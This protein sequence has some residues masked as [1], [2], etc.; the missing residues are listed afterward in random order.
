MNIITKSGPENPGGAVELNYGSYNTFSPQAVYGGSNKDGDLHYFVSSNYNRTDRGLDT[1]QPSSISNQTQGGT[2]AIHDESNGN[3]EFVKIDWLPN[4]E[5]KFSFMLFQNYNFYQIPNF[6]A[7]FG[8]PGNFAA[9]SGYF[10]TDYNDQVGNVPPTGSPLFTWAPADTND[11][12]SNQDIYGQAVW[13]HTFS[14]RSFLQVTPYWKYSKVKVTNDPANDLALL[15][16]TNP[17]FGVANYTAGALTS[18]ALDQHI[19]NLG[20]RTDYSQRPDDRNLFKTGFQVQATQSNDS[21]SVATDPTGVVAPIVGGDTNR[22]YSE[23]LYAQDD[24]TL[25]KQ[26]SINAGLRFT[27]VQFHFS[28]INTSYDQWQPRVGLNYL[29]TE[30]TKLHA[31]YGRLFMP[32][33]LENLR[34]AFDAAPGGTTANFYDIK[35]EKD[36]YFE[37]GVDQQIAQSHVTK[38][39]VYYKKATDMLDDTQLLNTSIASPYNYTEG[40]AYGI[41][42]SIFGKL[43]PEISDFFNYSYEIAKGKGID[44]GSFAVNPNSIP[45]DTYLYLDHVQVH[46]ANAG[47]TYTKERYF[48][49]VEG[50][51]GSGLRTGPNNTLSLP[52]HFTFDLTAGYDF[53]G[54]NWLTNWKVQGDILN[55]F[56][57]VYPITIANGF[58]GSH[59]AAGREFFIRLTKEL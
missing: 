40:Y 56:D 46:T 37:F 58:N 39:N 43:T 27:G 6:P 49:T 10:G 33:P 13:K 15:N 20:V 30:T 3:N 47:L 45:Q 41:E 53:K 42:Y 31:F 4:N 48:G 8:T 36:N 14:E 26:W 51:F 2:D 28:D 44:G 25:N 18:F 16:P 7:S 9:N 19:N 59:Y 24:F 5:D 38:V 21:F 29:A 52:S 35:P 23:A 17:L 57:N 22:G 34:E 12:Q 1:P 54:E 55:L 50:L 11:T 32:A